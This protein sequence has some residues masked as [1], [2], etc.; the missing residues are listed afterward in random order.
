MMERL[1]RR[2]ENGNAVIIMDGIV[3]FPNYAVVIMTAYNRLAAYE[4][5]GLTPDEVDQIRRASLTMMFPTVGDFVRNAI[6]N[7]EDLEKYRKADSENRLIVLPCKVGDPV[8]WNTGI[9]IKRAPVADFIIDSGMQLRLN[10]PT[11][12][13][14]PIYPYPGHLFLTREE[15]EAAMKEET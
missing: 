1:T 5:T 8:Y 14:T 7:F 12:G 11:L 6:Q 3:E 4:D 10:L 13:I 9:M 15:A 2:D